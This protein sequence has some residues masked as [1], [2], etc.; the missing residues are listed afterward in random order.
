LR[1]LKKDAEADLVDSQLSKYEL[2]VIIA[3]PGVEPRVEPG[4][5]PTSAPAGTLPTAISASDQIKIK[6]AGSISVKS[7][8]EPAGTKAS[9]EIK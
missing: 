7:D 5:K 8:T 4:V 3:E 9:A 6:A 1:K 2:P